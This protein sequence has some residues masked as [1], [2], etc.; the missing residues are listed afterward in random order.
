MKPN[1]WEKFKDIRKPKHYAKS[2]V[3]FYCDRCKEGF[4]GYDEF[5]A[6]NC[7]VWDIHSSE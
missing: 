2:K 5:D 3:M 7:G 6:H 1:R 4:P